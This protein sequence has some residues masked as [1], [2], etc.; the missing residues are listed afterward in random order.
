MRRRAAGGRG[1][2]DGLLAEVRAVKDL[3]FERDIR[4]NVLLIEQPSTFWIG[5]AVR[6]NMSLFVSNCLLE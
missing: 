3:S 1:D 5:N 2:R 4:S 6:S